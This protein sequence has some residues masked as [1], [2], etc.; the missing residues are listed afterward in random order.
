MRLLH[1][2]VS[3]ITR[4]NDFIGRWISYVIFALTIFLLIGIF[5]RYVLGAPLVWTTEA[6]QL[7]F[8]LYSVM[9][10]GYIMAHRGHVNVDLLYS[11]LPRRAQAGIDIFTSTLFFLFTGCLVYFGGTLAWDSIQSLESSYS[12]WNP[13]IYP[14]KAAIPVA[15]VLL[16]L[17]G[18]AKLIEDIEVA[19]GRP[20]RQRSN[21]GHVDT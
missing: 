9:A 12:A 20:D 7:L 5:Y 1:A 4:L 11:W 13:P 19:C 21:A 10:G 14:F 15:A 18:L 16:L 6:T 17:Q 3:G 8:G 2:F